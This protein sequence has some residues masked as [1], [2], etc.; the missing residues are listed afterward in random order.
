MC[1]LYKYFKPKSSTVLPDQEG[2]SSRIIP[3]STIEAV[4]KSVKKV[5][6]VHVE[7]GSASTTGDDYKAGKK[8]GHCNHYSAKDKETIGNYAIQHSA[9]ATIKPQ[10]P[11]HKWSTVK[12]SYC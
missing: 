7:F 6:D 1:S 5:V 8:Q 12:V 11:S 2:T 4:N 9:T 3:S 10:Y